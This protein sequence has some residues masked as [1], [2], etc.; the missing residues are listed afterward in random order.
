MGRDV[1]GHDIEDDVK[2]TIR[3][4]V[5]ISNKAH[6]LVPYYPRAILYGRG[7]LNG[8]AIL[9]RMRRSQRA[10]HLHA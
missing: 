6:D 7:T 2:G 5:K 8:S 1:D 9:W 3:I 4:E 10:H